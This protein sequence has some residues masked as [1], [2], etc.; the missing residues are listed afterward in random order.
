MATF[1]EIKTA[2][3]NPQGAR[4]QL[5]IVAFLAPMSADPISSLLDGTGA[6]QTIPAEYLPVGMITP[7]GITWPADTNVEEVEAL[8][9]AG[10]VRRDITRVDRTVTFTA[11]EAYK[12]VLLELVTGVDLSA[13]EVSLE[14]EATWDHPDIPADRHYRFLAIGR[15]GA[16]GAEFYR[17]RFL[18][19]VA[20]SEFP[21]EVWSATDPTQYPIT[22]TSFVDDAEGTGVREF[23]AGPGFLDQATANG[24]TVAAV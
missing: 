13:V 12:K 3:D 6:L 23:I 10:V 19:D 14:G 5:E 9:Y 8:G 2:A 7:D 16:P 20:L 18:P 17:G 15:D 1:A 22:L 24:W 11:L 4:K 21:E